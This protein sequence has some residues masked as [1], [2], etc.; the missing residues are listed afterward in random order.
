VVNHM[1]T[2]RLVTLILISSL[3]LAFGW[4]A[5]TTRA[6]DDLAETVNPVVLENQQP[7]TTAWQPPDLDQKLAQF[8]ADRQAARAF[9][10]AQRAYSETGSAANAPVGQNWVDNR[11]VEGYASAESV[12]AGDPINLHITA[13]APVTAVDIIVYRMGWYNGQGGRWIS[14]ITNIP[15]APHTVPAP[16]P[17]TGR[18]EANWP[19]AYTLHTGPDWVSGIYLIYI[20]PA[21]SS[22][23]TSHIIFVVRNDN[24]PADIVYQVAFSTYQAYNSWGGKSLYEYNSTGT[25][26]VEVSYD[27]PYSHDNGV[28]LFYSGDYNM[29]RWIES[30][31]YNVTYVSSGDVHTNP[32]L[33]DGRKVFLSNFHDEYY[34]WE[35]FDHVMAWRDQGKHQAWFTSN[36]IYW[37]IRYAPSSTGVPNRVIVCYKDAENDP[38]SQSDT[39]WLTTVLFR[40]P[41]VNRP[42]NQI[43]GIQF[44]NAMGFGEYFDYVV[45]NADH[46]IYEGTGLQNGSTIPMLVGYEYD[47]VY[48]NGFT[49]PGLTILSHSPAP[50]VYGSYANSS[51][52]TAPSGAMVFAAA[53][54]YW[55]YMLDGNWIWQRDAR[56]Q[57]I[58]TNI[59]N[60]M[61]DISSPSGT[62]TAT[63]TIT[64]TRTPTNT[65]TFGPSPT[66]TNTPTPSN[67]PTIT[68]TPTQTNTATFTPTPT[69]V[70][71]TFYRAINLGGSEM[72]ID[73]NTWEASTAPNFSVDGSSFCAPWITL[74]P[75]TDANRTQ[76]IRCSVEHWAHNISMSNVPADTYEVYLYVWSDWANPSPPSITVRLEGQT[77]QTGIQLNGAGEWLRVGP[78][79]ATINDGTINVTTSGGVV[80]VSGI[81]VYRLI[82]TNSTPTNTPTPTETATT[83]ATPT[84]GSSPTPTN[85]PTPTETATTT[86]TPTTGSSP[87]PTNTP[88]ITNTPT[89]TRTPTITNT[90]TPT[91]TIAPVTT[92]FYRAINLGGTELVIDGNTWEASTAPN[93]SAVGSSFCSP[94]ITLVPQTDTSRTQMIRCSVQH[95]AH[96]IVLSNVPAD[97]YDVYVYTWLDWANP[98]PASID[99]RLEGQT[100]QTGVQITGLGQWL[101]VGPYR[102][103]INDGTINLTTTGGVANISGIEVYRVLP[104]GSTPTNTPTPT[105]TL[106]ATATSTLE[107]TA[108]STATPTETGTVEAT[109]TPT[110]TATE[111]ATSEA[112]ATATATPTETGTVEATATSTATSTLEATATSTATPTETGTV[113]ATATPTETATATAT[114]E[115][116]ATP[117]NTLTSTP[118]A[119]LPPTGPVF[120]RGINFNGPALKIDGNQWESNTAPGFTMIGSRMCN[121]NVPLNPE[122]DAARAQMIRCYYTGSPLRMSL[123]IPN[124][125]YDIYVYTWEDSAAV[126]FDLCLENQTVLTGYNSGS[127]GTWRRLGPYQVDI[128]DGEI[129]LRTCGGWGNLSGIEVWTHNQPSQIT[130]IPGAPTSI[131]T[132]QPAN[133]TFYRAIN[134]NGNALTI[135]G[136]QWEGKT[137]PGYTLTGGFNM[138]N[139]TVPLN[140]P[141]D[142]ARAEMI[143]CHHYAINGRLSVSVPNGSYTIFFYTW[144]DN[145]NER[146]DILLENIEVA[147]DYNSGTAG[148]WQRLG[149]WT[150]DIVDG[151]ID[152]WTCGT[153]ANFSG[154]EIWSNNT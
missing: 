75:P 152:L 72:V 50:P 69:P 131:S 127:A 143:R 121:Q 126:S 90:P 9:S 109:A 86:A 47:R 107:A 139:Q 84:T 32:N 104:A 99:F 93:F 55:A 67:T 132:T 14:Q 62:P 119:T 114:L 70:T 102:A 8:A 91:S 5:T 111:T 71:A 2:R 135:D 136:N 128:A 58:T 79:R 108:T 129:N 85:T 44:Q 34:S 118:T 147:R 134:F 137:A 37:Q 120:Y 57:R 30:Q 113:E 149:P 92:S 22:Q 96:N 154:I 124:G 28:G 43:L 52:Y 141:T 15:V 51:I 21:G 81:E 27:R 48:D 153:W 40:D 56:V 25:P 24:R 19:V 1:S 65:P 82:P 130:P 112:T 66:P 6:Q 110:E 89:A 4:T 117:T 35:M 140:P 95:W 13:K 10:Q 125:I 100:V 138:C 63:P 33:M 103:T 29:V 150:V 144:E 60:R 87:T 39:P 98:S 101:R 18:I 83:T 36:N 115:A 97:T 45:T 49:P 148:T 54:N 123:N 20:N 142:D 146:Y 76:M 17:V 41:P 106:T 73:G 78:Y 3:L 53:T 16:D 74:T 105:E 122:T 23:N 80:N 116:T 151:S 26:A 77:V 59:L 46:W 11:V 7:G 64:N 88:T 31:G 145:Y 12:N 68:N 38:M 42:E 133:S 61:L 94:W